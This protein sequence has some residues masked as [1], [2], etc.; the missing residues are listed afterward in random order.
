MVGAPVSA[1]AVAA[2]TA[3]AS[4]ATASAAVTNGRIAYTTPGGIVRRIFVTTDLDGGDER[5]EFAVPGGTG[6]QACDFS[7]QR[8]IR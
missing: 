7:W 2:V 3:A 6:D 5:V 8:R 4:V 1:T